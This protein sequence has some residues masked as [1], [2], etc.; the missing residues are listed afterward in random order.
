MKG[1]ATK[2]DTKKSG[3]NSGETKKR[4]QRELREGKE[5]AEVL[6]SSSEASVHSDAEDEEKRMKEERAA[7]LI[8]INETIALL[9]AKLE[10]IDP[11]ETEADK[12]RKTLKSWL[13]K[14]QKEKSAIEGLEARK[15]SSYDTLCIILGLIFIFSFIFFSKMNEEF[16]SNF[17]W[18]NTVDFYDSLGLT[19]DATIADIKR[20]YKE[21][22]IKY[23][24]D[25]N[26]DCQDCQKQFLAV[27]EAYEVLGNEEKRGA[28][29]ETNGVVNF[30]R[31]G[32]IELT[33]SNFSRLVQKSDD[34]WIIQ[35]Y[36]NNSHSCE[37]FGHFWEEAAKRFGNK[38]LNKLKFGRVNYRSQKGLLKHLPFGITDLPFVLAMGR[39]IDAEFMNL[40][41]T[42]NIEIV[43]AKF[44]NT[45]VGTHIKVEKD[46]TEIVGSKTVL[47]RLKKEPR[48]KT[49]LNLF[50]L[51]FA[52]LFGVDTFVQVD[53]S[54][55]EELLEVRFN[56]FA[57]ESKIRVG[58]REL[59]RVIFELL[60]TYSYP[61]A[62]NRDSYANFC[63]GG[64]KCVIYGP[65]VPRDFLQESRD[66]VKRELESILKSEVPAD[67]DTF[68][69][70]LY[71]DG[72]SNPKLESVMSGQSSHE[73]IVVNSELELA[74]TGRW[75]DLN[76]IEE[77]N[78]VPLEEY[79]KMNDLFGKKVFLEDLLRPADYNFFVYTFKLTMASAISFSVLNIA[80]LLA[81]ILV[82]RRYK[83]TISNIAGTVAALHIAMAIKQILG[84]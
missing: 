37:R 44:I 27:Q 38:F 41:Y 71:N 83:V 42:S 45:V 64:V 50:A 52:K 4:A 78:H 62:L 25:K 55:L 70:L 48:E 3:N 7:K 66:F 58:Q 28:Y 75:M 18:T 26:S 72:L 24:P 63:K 82:K 34:I 53:P 22:A 54:L 47:L 51:T 39:E 65:K 68:A 13:E 12:K 69:H 11:R 2:H 43:L 73:V 67:Y 17:S 35:V 6:E 49:E 30:I 57:F 76:S 81:A 40:K 56:D 31:S 14:L 21:L 29:D 60:A 79:S 36:E 16:Y 10:K 20:K 23:H 19:P 9:S 84:M 32:T 8:E 59:L 33:T 80:L 1:K 74:H 5:E 46:R 15:R 61:I 77:I